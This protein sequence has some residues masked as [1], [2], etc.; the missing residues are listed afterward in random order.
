MKK[1]ILHLVSLLGCGSAVIAA[2]LPP[3]DAERGTLPPDVYIEDYY[4]PPPD[5]VP[6][7][8]IR[9]YALNTRVPDYFWLRYDGAYAL[10]LRIRPIAKAKIEQ[11]ITAKLIDPVK[12][13]GAL[14]FSSEAEKDEA[15][16]SIVIHKLNAPADDLIELS[17][18]M[19]ATARNAGAHLK[20]VADGVGALLTEK[21]EDPATK[22]LDG[23]KAY[24]IAFPARKGSVLREIQIVADP[25][26]GADFEQE[27]VIFDLMFRRSAPKARFTDLPRRQ[28]IRKQAF[29]EER[30]LIVSDGIADI[31]AFVDANPQDFP[32]VALPMA[33]HELRP[34]AEKDTDGG[35][36][37]EQVKVSLD[38][39]DVDALRITL[40]R[41]PRCYLKFP[42]AF[43]A[44]DYNTMTFFAKIQVP[45]GVGPL[46]GD[47]KPMLWGTD[48]AELNRPL[49]TFGIGLYSATHDFEDWGRWGVMQAM[50]TQ[51]LEA[52]AQAPAGW[53]LFGYDIVNSAPSGNKSAFHPKLTHWTFYYN[54][55][56]IPEGKE[57]VVTIA[58]P[59]VTR[60]LM[61]A[62]G[63]IPAYKK[64]M[65]ERGQW[66]LVNTSGGQ[67]ALDAPATNRLER[68]VRFIAD[69]VPRGAVYVD[70]EGILPQYHIVVR[71]AVEQMVDL[72]GR[73]YVAS[74]PIPVIE[75]RPPKDV[76]NAL[77]IGG[78]AYRE[79]DRERYDADMKA[80]AGTPGCAIRSDGVNV[81]IYAA[82]FNFAGPAR[83]L[84]NGIYTFLEN[85][86]DVIFA[87]AEKDDAEGAGAVFD[88]SPSGNFDIVWGRDYRNVPP[89]KVWG[90]SGV[91]RWHNDRNRAART[92]VWGNW[93]YAGYR[94]RSCNHWWGYGTG[95]NGLKGEPNET[96]GIGEDGKP[97]LP[98]CYTGHPCL[99]RVLEKAKEDYVSKSGFSPATGDYSGQFPAG[100][101][102]AWNSYD[103]HGLWVEDT[104]KVC[105]CSECATPIRLPDG[106]LVQRT[107]QEFLSTQFY[108]NGC[109]MINAV[110]VYANRNARIESIAYFWMTPIPRINISRNYNIR[111]CPYIRKDYFQPITAPIN[112]TWWRE[113]VRWS[114]M[115]VSTGLYEYFLF[116]PARPWAD[117][118]KY[119]LAIE[120]QHGMSEAI[121][122]G[123]SSPLCM[124]ERWVVTRLMWEPGHEVAD[125]REYFLRRTFREAAPEMERFFATLY[126]LVYR[127][128]A[129]FKPMEFEDLNDFGRLALRTPSGGN[130]RRTVADDLADNLDAAAKLVK[131]P[132][133]ARLLARFRE[134]W[135]EYM[136]GARKFEGGETGNK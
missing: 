88:G 107:E 126:G 14:A 118:F 114:Q 33:G 23:F 122:E 117:V 70:F 24:K 78:G 66:P 67:A 9:D 51:N 58:A 71:R 65:S 72:L 100:E 90:V 134:K 111:F 8:E 42:F 47:R 29:A 97:M 77:V 60:G 4:A 75:K 12:N 73:K 48:A 115:D 46:L 84:A 6:R 85:N 120:A 62:G 81:Y 95:S 131:N 91:P 22:C 53:R 26:A 123:D 105:Q 113:M 69:H 56:K 87:N 133:S 16:R 106:S 38:G 20:I 89:L 80:L 121:L 101:G 39:Q 30:P 45:T 74:V 49:D 2:S 125:L 103:V 54:N 3:P 82:P 28:W 7:R 40:T 136:A 18:K 27:Y 112:D 76:A 19:K 15:V 86:T 5:C 108:A 36:K 64:F 132:E 32:S 50:L 55:A 17:F 102:F 57:V 43:D 124:M 92:S 21:H 41:G 93:E 135:N 34:Q 68:P 99:I 104:R 129:P 130:A 13:T 127:D 25:A 119:D 94:G 128:Y 98:G 37:V 31:R 79:I 116:V 52:G 1:N 61:L 44:T 10:A 63:D 109:A 11:A 110:N 35:F 96:W 83:G 59:K